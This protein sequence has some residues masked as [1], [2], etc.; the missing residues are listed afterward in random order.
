[1]N[2]SKCTPNGPSTLAR[3]SFVVVVVVVVVI[4]IVIIVYYHIFINKPSMLRHGI[5]S[6]SSFLAC[7]LSCFASSAVRVY[8]E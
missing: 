6:P 2:Y 3:S 7:V 1:M 5:F 4:N 8:A